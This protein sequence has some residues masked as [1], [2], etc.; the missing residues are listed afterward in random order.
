MVKRTI[1]VVRWADAHSGA[2]SW[3]SID[4]L[5]KTG[6][7]VICS[8]GFLLPVE[9]GGRDHHVTLVQSFDD[10]HVDHVLHIPVGMVRSMKTVGSFKIDSVRHH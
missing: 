7:V 3:V 1:V 6:E 5:D 4:E 2:S 8:V 10:T 9:H